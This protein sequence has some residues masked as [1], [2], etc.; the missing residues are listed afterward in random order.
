MRKYWDYFKSVLRHKWYVFLECAKSG[1]IWQGLVHD[2]HKFLP[3]EFFAY[4]EK[5]YGT[6]KNGEG[7][8][9]LKA[10]NNFIV[11]MN[12]HMS[13]A[14][15]HWNY[16]VYLGYDGELVPLVMPKK[17]VVEMVCD[18]RGAG[19]AYTGRDNLI[20]W[21]EENKGKFTMHLETR[22]MVEELVYDS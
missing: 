22:R 4:A 2:W 8:E 21:Y 7:L 12:Y 14:K 19:K 18:W 17:Y 15:H 9:K 11:A 5:F 1:L 16:W 13:R 10:V 3:S 20:E 6:G